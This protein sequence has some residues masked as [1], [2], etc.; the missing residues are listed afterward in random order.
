MRHRHVGDANDLT[1]SL[2]TFHDAVERTDEHVRM[3]ED[4]VR[5]GAHRGNELLDGAADV[6]GDREPV[7]RDLALDGLEA[8]TS[9]VPDDL[10]PMQRVLF[11]RKP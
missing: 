5:V 2:K 10:D 8:R 9:R 3:I 6:I 7:W 11:W 1:A 4:S